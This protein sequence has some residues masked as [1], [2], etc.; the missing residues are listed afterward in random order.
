MDSAERDVRNSLI[1]MA[2][3]G[4]IGRR[5]GGW[6]NK[7][8]EQIPTYKAMAVKLIGDGL[9]IED[10]A[11]TLALGKG[12]IKKWMKEDPDFGQEMFEAEAARWDALEMEAFRRARE[13]VLE[14]VV[15]NGR[16]IMDPADQTKPLLVRKYSDGLTMFLLKGRKREIYGDKLPE[17]NDNEHSSTGAFERFQSVVSAA[18]EASSSGNAKGSAS[19]S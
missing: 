9:T 11:D 4:V 19:D 7:E 1:R 15:A 3:E 6:S 18:I 16:L 10:V 13:G 17:K 2:A 8:V 14:P 5:I 12:L